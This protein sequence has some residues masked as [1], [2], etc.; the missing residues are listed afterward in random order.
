MNYIEIFIKIKIYLGA[1]YLI[2]IFF[3]EFSCTPRN[4]H[5][6]KFSDE[7]KTQKYAHK[8]LPAN[9]ISDIH[10]LMKKGY[11]KNNLHYD[12]I[13]FN[14]YHNAKLQDS[15]HIRS[16]PHNRVDIIIG[17]QNNIKSALYSYL[18]AIGFRFYGPEN[19]W[20]FIP[21][22]GNNNVVDTSYYSPFLL[23]Q[24]NP[25]FSV[26]PRN[27]KS[28]ENSRNLFSRWKDRLR[29][30]NNLNLKSGHYGSMFNRKYKAQINSNPEWRG[31]DK[32][33]IPRPWSNE[34]KLCYSHPD[35]IALY[36][37]DAASRLNE[38]IK[39]HSPPYYINMEPPDGGN[40]CECDYCPDSVSDQVYG[41]ANNIASYLHQLDSNANVW[42]IAY[43]EHSPPPT[44][45]L[46]KNILIGIVPYAFQ[47]NFS[48]T[49]F[50][51]V[52]ENKGVPLFL[53]DYLAIPLWNFDEPFWHN[54]KS[55]IEKIRHLKRN[56]YVGF[57]F[58]SSAS[59]LSV[60]WPMYLISKESWSNVG[61]EK[62]LELFQSRMFPTSKL[63]LESLMD[64]FADAKN[65]S[66]YLGNLK[67]MIEVAKSNCSNE[68]E[69]KRLN[70]FQ[71]YFEYVVLRNEFKFN[72]GKTRQNARNKIL[73]MVY[74]NSNTLN[75]H[76]WG[77]YRSMVGN[78]ST[79]PFGEPLPVN[80]LTEKRTFTLRSSKPRIET[81]LPYN[82]NYKTQILDTLPI[83]SFNNDVTAMVYVTN[84]KDLKIKIRVRNVPSTRHGKGRVTI[85][86]MDGEE[87]TN[88]NF[89]HQN[90][91]WNNLEF[92]VPEGD[93]F[94]K[95]IFSNPAA[96]MSVQGPNRPY[97][98]ID[99]LDTGVLKSN[100]KL[101]TFMPEGYSPEIKFKYLTRQVKIVHEDG[102]IIDNFYVEE[103]M[104]YSLTDHGIISISTTKANYQLMGIPHLFSA[105]KEQLIK[106]ELK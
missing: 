22:L 93:K 64:Y 96:R 99:P 53:R 88:F 55:S 19:H 3:L 30:V 35:V 71:L 91:T 1:L 103:P 4:A 6:P 27:D 41:L 2:V 56:G 85:S 89:E 42:L 10:F 60:G 7:I 106:Y 68:S 48:P 70:D 66:Y 77:I 94:Y 62:E 87:I 80:K 37:K 51:E 65:S 45:E 101:W 82:P 97:S 5:P 67:Q 18:D 9:T 72:Q 49:E 90:T 59:F 52:W 38:K 73:N 84:D 50:K 54:G 44:F 81:Y 16:Q 79:T 95:I 26:G 11:E 98:F 21:T 12:S 13:Q 74:S 69:I 86:T 104:T 76:S 43:N 23:R 58:E 8:D 57:N 40:F 78:I 46:E 32:D 25:T 28:F 39:K 83:V 34:L 20:T 36:K 17:K 47:T 33:G 24:F 100:L 92:K 102:N 105:Q 14:V 31:K 75:L 63:D 29:V 61:Y 15:I